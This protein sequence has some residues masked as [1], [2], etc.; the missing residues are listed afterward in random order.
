MSALGWPAISSSNL[1]RTVELSP[2]RNQSLD[3]NIHG[4]VHVFVGNGQGMGSVPWAAGD[5]IFWMHH[6][7]ID[8]LWVSWNQT[9]TNPTHVAQPDIHFRNT[10]GHSDNRDRQGLH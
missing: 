9:H 5:P 7:N 1:A 2:S 8:R 10:G 3:Q 4:T 6:S